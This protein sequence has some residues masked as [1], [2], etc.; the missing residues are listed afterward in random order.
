MCVMMILWPTLYIDFEFAGMM[1][2]RLSQSS[3]RAREQ[4]LFFLVECFRNEIHCVKRSPRA[5]SAASKACQQQV[6]E[7]YCDKGA[8]TPEHNRG[9][10]RLV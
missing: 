7:M 3:G 4:I 8:L 9:G 1:R 6:K 10:A 2:D 5:L